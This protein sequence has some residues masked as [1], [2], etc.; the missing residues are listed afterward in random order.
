MLSSFIFDVIIFI[1]FVWDIGD[2]IYFIF[3]YFFIS[4]LSLNSFSDSFCNI[5]LFIDW[6]GIVVIIVLD[7]VLII[8]VE[9]IIMMVV[10]IVVGTV[11]II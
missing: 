1:E 2:N 5:L 4:V 3:K 11:V 6:I 7:I 9:N 8:V 10:G